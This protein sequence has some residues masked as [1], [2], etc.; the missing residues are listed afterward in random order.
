MCFQRS[1]WRFRLIKASPAA[2]GTITVTVTGTSGSLTHTTSA[3]LT[4]NASAPT[5]DFSLSASPSSLKVTR[6]H[7]VTSTITVNR[8]NGFSGRV[9]QLPVCR[10]GDCFVQSQQYDQS[11]S[12]LTLKARNTARPRTVTVT[13]KGV[14]SG[15]GHTTTIS[16]T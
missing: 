4:V 12:T 11:T 5:P 3:S 10:W 9:G 1:Q 16:L 2:V 7:R 8:L 13:I 14:S 15:S 6:G